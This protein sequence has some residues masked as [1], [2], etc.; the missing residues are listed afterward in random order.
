MPCNF[1][2]KEATLYFK[3]ISKLLK[4]GACGTGMYCNFLCNF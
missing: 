3:R 4:N 2:F 1:Q